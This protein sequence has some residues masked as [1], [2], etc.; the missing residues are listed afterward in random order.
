MDDDK[1]SQARGR[2][3]VYDI[4]SDQETDADQQ[5]ITKAS[6]R[7][8]NTWPKVFTCGGGR[9]KY[10]LTNWTSVTKG[11]GC[12]LNSGHD[13]SEAAPLVNNH[14]PIVERNP[15]VAIPTGR[16]QTY[17]GDLAPSKSR[18]DLAN[19]MWVRLGSTRAKLTNNDR[20]E[21]RQWQRLNDNTNNRT[22]DE[23][24]DNADSESK[25]G[26]IHSDASEERLERSL[27]DLE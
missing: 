3:I 23:T 20:P 24:G 16:V 10:P 21:Q 13:I 9:G 25:G 19:W 27:E 22:L 15:A 17:E 18:K 8:P 11:C 12:R 1:D 14:K 5:P 6:L 4:T 7:R 26:H 2:P